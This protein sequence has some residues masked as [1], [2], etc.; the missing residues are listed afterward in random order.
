MKKI[1]SVIIVCFLILAPAVS[2]AGRVPSAKS[3]RNLTTEFFKNY[4]K[5]Y[6]DS[7]FAKNKITKVEINQIHEQ[8]YQVVDIDAFIS[9]EDGTLVRA[10]LTARKKPPFS[11][12]IISWEILELK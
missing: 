5:K 4:S 11:W 3:A 8:S 7:I 9:L 1:L 10:L 6:K 12:K 2:Q